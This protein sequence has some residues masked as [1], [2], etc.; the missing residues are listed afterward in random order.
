MLFGLIFYARH[1][2]HGCVVSQAN[3]PR[4]SQK[5]TSLWFWSPLLLGLCLT[6]CHYAFRYSFIIVIMTSRAYLFWI[7]DMA[8]NRTSTRHSFATMWY[9]AR[10]VSS[11][12]A[13]PQ[14]LHSVNCYN[15]SST[16]PNTRSHTHTRSRE[17]W[18]LLANKYLFSFSFHI[19]LYAY[20]PAECD[21][22]WRICHVIVQ[23][24]QMIIK[25]T[26]VQPMF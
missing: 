18:D 14:V 2:K 3:C 23:I 15:Q 9:I 4:V 5:R 16:T 7:S 19:V 12:S 1:T 21:S 24:A 17:V 22:K 13:A 26:Q 10:C 25:R 20:T 11:R 8:G 6:I